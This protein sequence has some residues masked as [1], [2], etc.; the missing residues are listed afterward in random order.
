MTQADPHQWS[1]TMAFGVPAMDRAHE[2]LEGELRR[3]AD[4]TDDAFPGSLS[5]L[6]AIVERDFG[7]EE[8][9][10]EEIDFPALCSH[11]E[12]HARV[13][14]GLHHA[15]SRVM[16]GDI[17]CGRD[18]VG[19]LTTWFPMHVA[20]MDMALAVALDVGASG[21]LDPHGAPLQTVP[22]S[23]ADKGSDIGS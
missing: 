18:A 12:Q 8:R 2:E 10:M 16:A 4:A 23:A 19:L 7:D 17:A 3:L 15:A 13:L 6:I 22:E 11:R 20:T 1:R 9:W 21:R 5:R 14:S